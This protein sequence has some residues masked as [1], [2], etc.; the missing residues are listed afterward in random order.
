MSCTSPTSPTSPTNAVKL[1]FHEQTIE[2]VD[3]DVTSLDFTKKI[4]SDYSF[5]VCTE[6]LNVDDI[7]LE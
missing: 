6:V 2:I 7:Y 5:S 4:I 3:E 1:I